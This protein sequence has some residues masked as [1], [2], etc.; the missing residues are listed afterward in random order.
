MDVPP[1]L[2]MKQSYD[3]KIYVPGSCY[4]NVNGEHYQVGRISN[5]RF[6]E[7]KYEDSTTDLSMGCIKWNIDD[8]AS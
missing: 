3:L 1:K 4:S 7:G 8:V 6:S 5:M 2:H